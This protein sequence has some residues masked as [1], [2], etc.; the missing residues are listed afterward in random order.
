MSHPLAVTTLSPHPPFAA[1]S[2]LLEEGRP[3]A[4]EA[5]DTYA[6]GNLGQFTYKV[7]NT[8]DAKMGLPPAKK[9]C[10]I[11]MIDAPLFEPHFP[12][13]TNRSDL[14]HVDKVL[15]PRKHADHLMSLYWRIIEPL[16]PLLDQEHFSRSYHNLFT[17]GELDCDEHIFISTLN[18]IFALSTQ[19]QESTPPEQR[20]EA[21]S[22]FF[23]RAWSLL[24]PETILWEPASLEL[25]QCLL[26]VSRYLQCT[27]NSHQ[28]WMTVGS[29][30][31]LAQSI[32]LH[33]PDKPSLNSNPRDVLLRRQIWQC[34]VFMDRYE[35]KLFSQTSTCLC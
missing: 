8:I 33:V 10:P 28:T 2:T 15:P 11:P 24:R 18:A 6:E 14:C 21:S 3:D 12:R 22:V 27:K 9:R 23:Q 17:G 7:K 13:Q 31:R 1:G 20:D 30:L 35:S 4:F 32:N 5:R 19:L 34:C 16:E 29:A 26:L 25:V